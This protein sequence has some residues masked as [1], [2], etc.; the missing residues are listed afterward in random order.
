MVLQTNEL[1]QIIT[2]LTDD[3]GLKVTVNESL[4]GGLITGIICTIGGL[5]LG[6]AGLAFGGTVGNFD[7]KI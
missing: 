3:S 1:C 5:I 6:P 4:K 7:K 2:T